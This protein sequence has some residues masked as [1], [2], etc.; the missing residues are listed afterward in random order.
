MLCERHNSGECVFLW[1]R[2][3]S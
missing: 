2:G 1:G 3:N